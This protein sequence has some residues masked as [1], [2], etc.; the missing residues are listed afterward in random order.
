MNE[1]QKKRGRL[2]KMVSTTFHRTSAKSKEHIKSNFLARLSNIRLIRLQVVEWVLLVSLLILLAI[3]QS[4]WYETSYETSV[5]TTGGTYSEATLG[6]INS[7]NPLYAT[8]NS[9]KTLARLLF[10]GLTA[11]D[12]SG[13]I[14]N[15]LAAS[16]TPAD[17]GKTWL[18]QLKDNL[19]WSDGEP[20]TTTDILYTFNIVQSPKSKTVYTSN[21]TNVSLTLEDDVL[22]FALPAAYVD[23][24][25]AL[26]FPI[27]PAHILSDVAPESLFAH[28]FSESP[29]GSGPFTLNALQGTSE[30]IVY[31][32][33]NPLY[34]A[35]APM[36]DRF[37]LHTYP[38]ADAIIKSLN[39]LTV[40]ATAELLPTDAP[41]ITSS[42]I[43]EKQTT[44]MNGVFAF[45]NCSSEPL[46]DA[47]TRRALRQGIDMA[48]LR[49]D[50]SEP[51]LDFPILADSGL[52]LAFPDLPAYDPAAANETLKS[53]NLSEPLR[54]ATVD[55]GHFPELA[56]RLSEQLDALG[57]ASE[58]TIVSPAEVLTT[59][60]RPRNYDILIY[61]IELGA[62]PDP[63][64][65]FHSSQVS[66]LG[67]NL[68]N[69]KN[70][71]ADDLLLAARATLDPKLR[72]A[73]YATFLKTWAN[74]APAI[75]IYQVNMSYYFNK[76]ARTFSESSTLVTPF[77]R[78]ADVLYWA[79][80]KSPK[81][82]TP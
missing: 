11:Y 51:A 64:P 31:L 59:I 5:F 48:A 37:S 57:V 41:S 30:Q 61:E 67:L 28:H 47:A 8:T 4:I 1:L 53:L 23:F 71:V 2:Q 68:S 55:T 21:L 19:K 54:I 82:R 25:E 77:D 34:H 20:L 70:S 32:N 66:E 18:V 13:H 16:I 17:N 62:S 14:S 24:P 29:I 45:L 15:D 56:R 10:S 60:I 27:L 44:I 81:N 38:T 39:S 9:E 36:L 33:N 22:R 26:T 49:A 12:K 40:T 52:A 46:K 6:K 3:I 7:L 78:F 72:A 58:T 76:S 50:L 65:Y 75:G 69:Y 74:D 80:E 79:T 63:F 73:K 35:G 43:Y 42:V